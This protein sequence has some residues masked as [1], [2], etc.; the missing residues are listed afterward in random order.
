MLALLVGML[1]VGA[2][3]AA[4]LS[5]DDGDASAQQRIVGAPDAVDDAG[6]FTYQ[7]TISSKNGS[8]TGQVT[9]DG[10]VDSRAKR[11]K[12]SLQTGGQTLDMVTDAK[13]LYVRVPD[14]AKS[15][16]NGK[17]WAKV[18]GAALGG[19]V[20]GISSDPNPMQSFEQLR[21]AGSDVEDLGTEE[22]RGATTTH[23]RTVLDLGRG[24]DRLGGTTASEA[25]ALREQLSAVPVD[26]WLDGHDRVRRQR[27]TL[28]LTMPA[29]SGAA[30]SR[31]RVTSTVEAFD[32]GKPVSIDRP[33]ADD[34]HEGGGIPGLQSLFSAS[35]TD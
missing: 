4:L 3:M 6:T 34:V 12:A 10:A 24:L 14:H 9:L 30:P 21:R 19:G 20:G 15:T 18:D 5:A 28:E 11:S 8:T 33:A 13:F 26:V 1:L 16:T 17:G 23:Y 2:G 31:T 32:F 25:A 29:T 35:K 22:V 7:M 27:T